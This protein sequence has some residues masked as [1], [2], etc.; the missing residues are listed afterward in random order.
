MRYVRELR[1][2]VKD[3]KF[4][5]FQ[6][7]ADGEMTQLRALGLGVQRKQAEPI[8]VKEENTLWEAGLLDCNSHKVPLYTMVYLCGL[9]FALRSGQEHC[10]L[11]FSQIEIVEASQQPVYLIYTENISK[12]N[13]GGLA[14]EKPETKQVV[15]HTNTKSLLELRST[16][17]HTPVQSK[18]I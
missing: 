9:S 13:R 7:T 14:Q 18:V 8:S 12:T 3:S 16:Q 1:P 11:Q 5:G 6:K 15:H 2:Q 17:L 10:D 4:A